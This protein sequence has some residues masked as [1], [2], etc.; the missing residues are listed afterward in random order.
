MPTA[1][2][3]VLTLA[4]DIGGSGLKMLTL[5]ANGEPLYETP[6]RDFGFGIGCVKHGCH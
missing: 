4:I 1:A 2:D 5:D 6:N 3:D